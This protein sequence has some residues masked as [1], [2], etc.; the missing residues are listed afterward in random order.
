MTSG[1]RCRQP[2][3]LPLLELGMPRVAAKALP[4]YNWA[5]ATVDAMASS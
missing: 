5:A 1:G 3:A 2:E 4:G